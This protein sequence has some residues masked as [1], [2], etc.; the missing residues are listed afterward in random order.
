[1]LNCSID[2]AAVVGHALS[3][4]LVQDFRKDDARRIVRT[5]ATA[6]GAVAALP[7]A[8][9]TSDTVPVDELGMPQLPGSFGVCSLLCSITVF[10]ER[11]F[12]SGLCTSPVIVLTTEKVDHLL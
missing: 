5:P 1:M 3:I 8:T 6:G 11:S 7:P 2:R 9:G 4:H 12:K 10:V